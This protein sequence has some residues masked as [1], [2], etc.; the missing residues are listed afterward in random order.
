LSPVFVSTVAVVV[1]TWFTLIAVLGADGAFQ[2]P[3]D[4]PPLAI[5]A[6]LALPPV[7]F[8]ILLR[9]APEFRRQILAIDPVWLTS[10]QGLRIL[11][12]GFLLLYAYGLLPGLFAHPAGWGDMTVAVLAPFVATRLARDPS[13]LVSPWYWRFHVLGMLDFVGAV[14][15]GLLARGTWPNLTGGATTTMLGDLP[16]VL[17]PAFAVPL[18]ICLHLTAFTQIRAA[19]ASLGN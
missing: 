11:G 16:L 18:W 6:A 13:F 8:L 17:I 10:V 5:L 12:G 7:L 1:A 14:G 2:E 4:K 19:R 3:P 9:T 15:S